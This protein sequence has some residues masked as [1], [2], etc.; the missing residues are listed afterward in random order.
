M[1][2]PEQEIAA[3]NY[4]TVQQVA[5]KLQCTAQHVNTLIRTGKLAPVVNIA[6]GRRAHYRIAPHVLEAFIAQATVPSPPSE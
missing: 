3:Y 4:L 5:D 6:V 2:T 1:R